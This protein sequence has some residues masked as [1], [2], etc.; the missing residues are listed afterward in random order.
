MNPYGQSIK[1][2]AVEGLQLL[3]GVEVMRANGAVR[4]WFRLISDT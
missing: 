1:R 2:L 4:V 3:Q